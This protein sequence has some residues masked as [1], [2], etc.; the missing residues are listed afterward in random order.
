MTFSPSAEQAAI[1]RSP[2]ASARIA[3][4]AGTGKT[5]TI[6]RRVVHLIDELGIHP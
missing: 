3:A 6:S 5:T 1:I 4:G 2:L